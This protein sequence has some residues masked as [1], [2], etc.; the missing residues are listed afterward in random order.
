MFTINTII[1]EI[2]DLPPERLEEVYDFVHSLKS[3][4]KSKRKNSKK[5]LSFA[6]AFSD[7]PK[8]DYADLKEN[9]ADTRK[10]L[11]DRSNNI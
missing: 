7:M 6:G 8:N 11:F 2:N 9:M 3:E 1:K 4:S 5:I 10:S